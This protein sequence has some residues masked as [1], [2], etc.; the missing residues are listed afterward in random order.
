MCIRDSEQAAQQYAAAAEQLTKGAQLAQGG[1]Q[2]IGGVRSQVADRN[3]DCTQRG[4]GIT[5]IIGVDY[6]WGKLNL[7]ARL[8][9][10]THLNIEND[11]KVD[12]RAS[13]PTV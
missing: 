8:E 11:T 5:P 10:T 3:L 1:A 12:D 9:F 2:A 4:W 6:R 7:G 13:S